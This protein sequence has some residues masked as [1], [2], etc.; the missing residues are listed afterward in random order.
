ML[1]RR[2]CITFGYVAE[3]DLMFTDSV[4]SLLKNHLIE[5]ASSSTG[6]LLVWDTGE[7][8]MLPYRETVEQVT[9][10]ELSGDCSSL[11]SNLSDSEKLHAAFQNVGVFS[12][13]TSFDGTKSSLAQ[14]TNSPP[15]G[16]SAVWIHPV[17]PSPGF[18]KS[19]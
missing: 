13:V 18:G 2:G 1:Q 12:L 3:R 15:W 8:E 11:T 5:T 6:S 10:D 7:Y 16:S 4:L 14:N 9:D 17:N 19:P